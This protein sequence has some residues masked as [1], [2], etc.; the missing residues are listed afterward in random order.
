M[1]CSS[2]A[3]G[4]SASNLL[5]SSLISATLTA[6]GLL[7]IFGEYVGHRHHL[8]SSR[9]TDP[10]ASVRLSPD[11]APGLAD[12][13]GDGRA[14]PRLHPAAARPESDGKGLARPAESLSST[15]SIDPQRDDEEASGGPAR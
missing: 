15:L 2:S 6:G 4:S 1:P 13:Q 12:G 8:H 7:R 3:A 9:G 14:D 5:N 10:G 11:E